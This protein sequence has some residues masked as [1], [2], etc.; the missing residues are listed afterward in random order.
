MDKPSGT[1]VQQAVPFFTVPDI[2]SSLQFYTRGLGFEIEKIGEPRGRIEWCW[3]QLGGAALMLQEHP[4]T[5][6]PATLW[7]G[8]KKGVCVSI[9]FTCLDAI[10][11]YRPQC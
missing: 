3:L 9:N 5:G 1:N 7:Q 6:E 4:K 11:L 2:D 8:D 10:A